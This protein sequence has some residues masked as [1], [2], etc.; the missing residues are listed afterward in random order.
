MSADTVSSSS[1]GRPQSSGREQGGLPR[2]DVRGIQRLA[3]HSRESQKRKSD[4]IDEEES[5]R[6]YLRYRDE[7]HE[8]LKGNG[9]AFFDY[10]HDSDH[11]GNSHKL[12]AVGLNNQGTPYCH[13]VL[14]PGLSSNF[15][16][17]LLSCFILNHR[18]NMLSQ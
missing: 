11:N 18:C 6:L 4:G 9:D 2:G 14:Q 10:M 16:S 1:S 7:L 15:S 3:L 17:S 5:I 8:F 13:G 12:G